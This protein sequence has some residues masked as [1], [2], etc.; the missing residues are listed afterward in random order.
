MNAI[1]SRTHVGRLG[2]VAILTVAILCFCV[3]IAV[4]ATSF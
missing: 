2:L 3:G 1:A 4:A